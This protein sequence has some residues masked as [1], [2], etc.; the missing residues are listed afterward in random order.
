MVM[1]L[2]IESSTVDPFGVWLEDMTSS[3]GCSEESKSSRVETVFWTKLGTRFWS[4]Q[5]TGFISA[6][7]PYGE[8]FW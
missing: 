4:E 1:T 5:G 8:P 6:L 2:G 7:Y 3:E